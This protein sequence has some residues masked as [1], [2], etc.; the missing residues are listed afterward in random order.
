MTVLV[1]DDDAGF[2]EE[3]ARVLAD[4]ATVVGVATPVEALWELE[5]RPVDIL[6]CDLMLAM[7]ADGGD[8]LAT[9]RD[10]WPEVGRIVVTGFGAALARADLPAHAI[11]LKPCDGGVLRELLR[12]LPSLTAAH[13]S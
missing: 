1:L 13:R 6:I 11:M 12:M 7:S 10:E 3:M 9:V 5:R 8:V 2:R 4:A